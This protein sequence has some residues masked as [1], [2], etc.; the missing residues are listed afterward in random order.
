M[1]TVFCGF[2]L[3]EQEVHVTKSLFN[4]NKPF[5]VKQTRWMIYYYSM[6]KQ[7]TN[8]RKDHTMLDTT[9]SSNGKKW[10]KYLEAEL[11]II[12]KEYMHK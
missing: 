5:V 12:C 2:R 6:S 4:P 9:N 3:C 7:R 8:Y 11:S 10:L 1:P